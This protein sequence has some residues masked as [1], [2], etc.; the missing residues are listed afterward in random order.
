[1]ERLN[2]IHSPSFP[3]EGYSEVFGNPEIQTKAIKSLSELAPA[4]EQLRVVLFDS[5][6]AGNGHPDLPLDGRT[7]MVGIGLENAEWLSDERIFLN[8]PAHPPR[9]ALLSAIR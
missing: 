2:V 7:A 1:M 5:T 6:F 3:T 9:T 4:G 8:L